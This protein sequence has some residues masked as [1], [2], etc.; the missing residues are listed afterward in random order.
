MATSHQPDA[1]AGLAEEAVLA[2]LGRGD[3]DA[4]TTAALRAYG[5]EVFSFL[6]ALH[7]GEDDAG[8]AY[9]LFCE[10]LWAS[11]ERF[12]RSCSVRTWAYA[13]ARRSSLRVRRDGRRRAARQMAIPESSSAFALAAQVR[14]ETASWLATRTRTRIAEL[15]ASLP[16]EDQALLMLRV[17]RGLAWSDL[18]RVLS[19]EPLDDAALRRVSARLRKRFQLVRERLAEMGRREGLV[20]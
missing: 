7:P 13:I 3:R 5:G 12:E 17:D 14:S 1:G 19:E 11:F 18:A 6:A 2:A 15:R 10:G 16:E 4:A 8:D 9:S 20:P